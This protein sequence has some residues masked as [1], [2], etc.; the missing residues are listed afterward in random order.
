MLSSP[1]PQLRRLRQ[2]VASLR[3]AWQQRDPISN[4]KEKQM[5]TKYSKSRQWLAHILWGLCFWGR[6]IHPVETRASAAMQMVK[7]KLQRCSRDGKS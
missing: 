7:Y 5:K 1:E 2:Q 4:T 6:V 3:P